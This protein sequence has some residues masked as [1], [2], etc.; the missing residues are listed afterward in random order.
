MN[1]PQPRRARVGGGPAWA[2]LPGCCATL[3]RTK[4]RGQFPVWAASP[5]APWESRLASSLC[6]WPSGGGKK[7]TLHPI[8]THPGSHP[9][10]PHSGITHLTC[11]W[12]RVQMETVSPTTCIGKIPTPNRTL[13]EDQALQSREPLSSI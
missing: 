10:F 3:I 8:H 2:L 1:Y 12:C 6:A 7:G 9:P 13:L 5:P 4:G 11:S